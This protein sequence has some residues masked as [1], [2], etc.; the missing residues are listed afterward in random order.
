MIALRKMVSE[1]EVLENVPFSRSTLW[2]LEQAK[3]FPQSI[4]ISK[5][6]RCWF[7]DDVIQWQSSVNEHQPNR[8]RG[9]ARSAVAP[10]LN[11]PKNAA[12]T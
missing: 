9:K 5:N 10:A 3:K 12:S 1:E 4:Y 8:K 11:D 7:L 2:R 6:R